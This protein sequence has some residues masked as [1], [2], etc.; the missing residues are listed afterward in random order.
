MRGKLPKISERGERGPEILPPLAVKSSTP[1]SSNN[2]KN[3]HSLTQK[4]PILNAATLKCPYFQ[5][6]QCN[7]VRKLRSSP[8]IYIYIYRQITTL[9]SFLFFYEMRRELYFTDIVYNNPL[10][11]TGASLMCMGQDSM[12]QVPPVPHVCKPNFD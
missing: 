7:V 5:K 4:F 1:F 2:K 12:S 3:L 6:N 11:T 9:K 10:L 8:N